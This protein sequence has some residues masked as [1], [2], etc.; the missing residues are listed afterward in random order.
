MCDGWLCHRTQAHDRCQAARQLINTLFGQLLHHAKACDV[1]RLVTQGDVRLQAAL[2]KPLR[3]VVM[4]HD[5]RLP[6][7][8]VKDFAMPPRHGHVNTQANGFAERLFG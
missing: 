1:F 2:R 8:M 3:Q 7:D 5:M 6:T 4:Q